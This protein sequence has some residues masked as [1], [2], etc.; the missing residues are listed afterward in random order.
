M[1]SLLRPDPRQLQQ[2]IPFSDYGRVTREIPVQTH[3]LDDVDEIRAMD[4]LKIDVQGFELTVFQNGRNKLAEAVAL[5][6]ESRL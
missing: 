4:F 2:F 6:V 5:Q 1:S 3:H